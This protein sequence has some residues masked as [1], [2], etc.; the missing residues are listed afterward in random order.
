MKE[1]LLIAPD[2]ALKH[3]SKE[4]QA[5]I[6]SGLQAHLLSGEVTVDDI[7]QAISRQKW[8]A[9]WISS[10]GS[11]EGVLLSDGLLDL[12]LLAAYVRTAQAEFVYLNT[13][14]SYGVAATI[15]RETRADL[16]CT[17]GPIDDLVAYSTGALFA[18]NLV[19]SQGNYRKAYELAKP[20][21]NQVYL[22]L[23]GEKGKFMEM[24]DTFELYRDDLQKDL[25][26]LSQEL[27]TLRTTVD[28][29]MIVLESLLNRTRLGAY[30]AKPAKTLSMKTA[31][32]LL[33]TCM[34]ASIL[35]AVALFLIAL[36]WTHFK[37]G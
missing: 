20:G 15:Q 12:A 1:I 18:H 17:V 27:F 32:L 33:I 37:V 35:L 10:H 2:V 26:Q 21:G 23:T 30:G 19:K 31:Y 6:N 25:K 28:A 36:G 4:V 5:I 3:T 7:I 11:A 9:I 29:R 22:Y 24:R 34:I 8:R 16:I 14:E 13:C